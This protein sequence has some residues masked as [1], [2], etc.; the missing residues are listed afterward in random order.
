[1]LLGQE[2]CR[3]NKLRLER[4]LFVLK[5]AWFCLRRWWWPTGKTQSGC[6]VRRRPAPWVPCGAPGC[7]VAPLGPPVCSP[8][9]LPSPLGDCCAPV[10]PG[11]LPGPLAE[12]PGSLLRPWAFHRQY[13]KCL[14]RSGSLAGVGRACHLTSRTRCGNRTRNLWIRRPSPCPLCEGGLRHCGPR[15]LTLGARQHIASMHVSGWAFRLNVPG[16]A[17]RLR[18]S[19]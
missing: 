2:G 10:P 8:G 14:G 4:R 17:F 7:P 19:S 16:L 15:R 6:P 13:E 5:C 9:P 3:K 18:V 11:V 12:P 1:M